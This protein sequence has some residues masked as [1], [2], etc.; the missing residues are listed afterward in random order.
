MAERA[1]IP[2]ENVE[3]FLIDT[4]QMAKQSVENELLKL[5]IFVKVDANDDDEQHLI[6][7]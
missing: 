5:N 6:E 7:M 2:V 3:E 1:G 4:P